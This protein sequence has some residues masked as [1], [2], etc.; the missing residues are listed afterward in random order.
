MEEENY[1]AFFSP[2]REMELCKEINDVNPD[3]RRVVE[4]N[5]KKFF[6]S[7]FHPF[8]TSSAKLAV[9]LAFPFPASVLNSY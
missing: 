5:R 7:P 3:S 9:S 4:S 1:A 2:M 8:S 6:K